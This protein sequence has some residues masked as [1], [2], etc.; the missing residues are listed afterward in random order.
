MPGC[1]RVVALA[2]DLALAV[3]C[4]GRAQGPGG[5]AQTLPQSHLAVFQFRSI[6]PANMFLPF[7]GVWG[8]RMFNA[9]DPAFGAWIHYYLPAHT[10][11]A[12]EAAI[13]G[14]SG[15]TVRK[16][17]GTHDPGYNRV[18][19]DLE[20]EEEERI[21]RTEQKE[22]VPPGEYTVTL[23]VGK[24]PKLVTRLRVESP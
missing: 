18:V 10:T 3:S 4:A 22:F 8:D 16:L 2:P 7:G 23:E 20:P 21:E 19:R 9:A 13:A 11:G 14:A 15:R 12:V 24:G 6:G 5:A 1:P 17:P